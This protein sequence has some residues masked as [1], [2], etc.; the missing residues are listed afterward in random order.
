MSV[1]R[2][3]VPAAW[4]T[5][6]ITPVP[7]CTPVSGVSDLWLWL[8]LKRLYLISSVKE[9]CISP[10]ASFYA[11]LSSFQFRQIN[12]IR[13]SL[14][15][16]TARYLVKAFAVSRLDCC[17][18]LYANLLQAAEKTQICIQC[19]GISHFLPIKVLACYTTSSGPLALANLSRSNSSRPISCA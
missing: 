14:Q 2:S 16:E 10:Y 1:S 12:S 15:S 8:Y 3:V 18:S 17:N 13:G 6:V 19:G 4:R 5:V 9:Y 11:G 7:K